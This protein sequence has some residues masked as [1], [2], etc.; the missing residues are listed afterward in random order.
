MT[1]STEKM[2]D[3]KANLKAALAGV[4]DGSTSGPILVTNEGVDHARIVIDSFVDHAKSSIDIF[5][6]K[7]DIKIF[8]PDKFRSFIGKL[9]PQKIRLLL[10]K[11]DCNEDADSL[12]YALLA[13]NDA[14]DSFE[15]R[16]TDITGISHM[17]IVDGRHVRWESSQADRKAFVAID[18]I[19]SAQKALGI[20]NMIWGTAS[21]T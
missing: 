11:S 12:A 5:A 17:T 2:Q 10:E 20:F 6:Q 9:G 13:R 14:N 15:L 1:D 21:K 7:A 16:C 18:D 3:Y 4:D 19:S 8:D